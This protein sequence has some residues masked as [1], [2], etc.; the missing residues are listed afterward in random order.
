MY[1]PAELFEKSRFF[2]EKSGPSQNPDPKNWTL[3]AVAS[4]KQSGI[5]GTL[6]F[7]KI[8]DEMGKSGL[9]WEK[10]A[11]SVF[12]GQ[13]R[14]KLRRISRK[15]T[16]VS[17]GFLCS[18]FFLYFGEK[19]GKARYIS[20][21]KMRFLGYI[22]SEF[23]FFNQFYDKITTFLWKSLFSGQFITKST[24]NI[25]C[26]GIFI[27]FLSIFTGII[28]VTYTMIHHTSLYILYI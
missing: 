18:L 5:L 22:L 23:L 6:C 26:F 19:V 15:K 13:K 8:W 27:A 24:L 10:C 12:F 16:S 4:V 28:S 9:F 25:A 7:P 17:H 20:C 11:Q 1:F 3:F 21:I 2:F 14:A